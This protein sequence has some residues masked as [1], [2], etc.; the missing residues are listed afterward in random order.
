MSV[1]SDVA[2]RRFNLTHLEPVEL[3]GLLESEEPMPQVV[4]ERKDVIRSIVAQLGKPRTDLIRA[5]ADSRDL[6]EA[7]EALGITYG[8]AGELLSQTMQTIAEYAIDVQEARMLY[9]ELTEQ[10]VGESRF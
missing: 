2:K 9:E 3:E 1:I 4:L 7:A 5:L 6:R 10:I 8:D